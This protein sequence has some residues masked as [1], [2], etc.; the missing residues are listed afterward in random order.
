[1]S[2]N[3]Q[4][5]GTM[6]RQQDW[7]RLLPGAVDYSVNLAVNFPSSH[8]FS[9]AILMIILADIRQEVRSLG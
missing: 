6:F 5:L 4:V 9:F 3:P 7:Q 8:L 2:D 1:M